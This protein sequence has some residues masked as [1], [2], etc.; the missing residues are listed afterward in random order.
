M[1]R[2]L[3]IAMLALLSLACGQPVREGPPDII[4]VCMDT[5][6][7]DRLG[8]YGN[9]DGLSPSIDRF[10]REAVVFD[11]AWAVANET[12][13]SHAA[14]FTSRYATETGDI[15]ETFRL[16]DEPP[17]L[18]SVLGVYGYQSAA[19]TGGGH[20]SPAFGLGRGF[21]HWQR[22][23]NWGSLYHSVPSALAWWDQQRDPDRPALLFVHGYD[24][25]HRYL[26]PGPWGFSRVDA[27]YK[28]VA[29]DMVRGALGTI[30]A[31]DGHYFP[32]HA[33][34]DLL[35]LGALRIR[36]KEERR[37]IERMSNERRHGARDIE[38][39]DIAYVRGVYDGAVSYGDTWFGL[40]MS[41]LERRGALDNA[42]VVLL[43]D[44]GE[45]LGEDGLFHHRYT[46]SDISL[47]VPL[48]VRLPGGQGGGRHVDGAVDLTD[49][50]P[51]LLEAGG[52][53]APAGIRGRSL[54]PAL[55]GQPLEPRPV[56]FSQSMFR[57]VS[58]RSDEGRLSFSGIGADSPYLAA[59]LASTN[60]EGPAFEASEG[61]TRD[62]REDLRQQLTAWALGLHQ[63]TAAGEVQLTPE[64]LE[65]I[66]DKGY[67]GA[68]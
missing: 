1:L 33:P 54:W 11:Q 14:L 38:E 50:M 63:P 62:Q 3:A 59:M 10:A 24:T 48:L 57:S 6:R 55:Q 35:D 21:D 30:L 41:T 2:A 64:Q 66:Q 60:L 32:R 16:A 67:W 43:S 20:L 23:A 7:A 45:E 29:A 9:P 15:F 61:L 52:A 22:S 4:V 36:G 68:Q 58:V 46:L 49:L 25:H 44:H 19:F 39:Q 51:T 34:A 40:L 28:G 12:L 27:S 56:T 18:A 8:V 47:Q 5:L 31:V 37:R 42:V 26:K 53:Q 17:T 65:V 13:Y